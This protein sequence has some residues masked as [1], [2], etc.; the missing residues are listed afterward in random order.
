MSHGKRNKK[1]IFYIIMVAIIVMILAIKDSM[2]FLSRTYFDDINCSKLSFKKAINKIEQETRENVFKFYF[3]DGNCYE[4]TYVEVGASV[5]RQKL[6]NIFKDQHVH[7]LDRRNYRLNSII[8]VNKEKITDYLKTIPEFQVEKM[9]APQDAKITWDGSKFD[10]SKEV[11][12]N[13]I[14]FDYAVDYALQQIDAGMDSVYFQIITNKTPEVL[15]EDLVSLKDYYNEIIRSSLT[16]KLANGDVITLDA[17]TMKKWIKEDKNGY[18][19]DVTQGISDF[20]NQLA[21]KVDEANK[22]IPELSNMKL[23]KTVQSQVIEE[24]LELSKQNEV[25]IAYEKK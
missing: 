9:I 13:Q 2:H 16:F 14:D 8:E 18:M 4:A 17:E 11:I 5:N 15:A 22:N 7:R 23:N 24:F 25:E 19:L 10:V 21:V 6:K 20:V 1:V 12:G 3:M